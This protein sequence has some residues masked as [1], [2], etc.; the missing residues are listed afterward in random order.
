MK[1]MLVL[2]STIILLSF[3]SVDYSSHTSENLISQELIGAWESSFTTPEG[4]TMKAV[5]IVAE[6]YFSVAVFDPGQKTFYGTTGGKWTATGNTIT[7]TF[8]YD[9]ITK[10]NVG[11]SKIYN[12]T[13]SPTSFTI[14]GEPI[15]NRIDYGTPGALAGPWLITGRKRNGEISRRTPGARK[16]MKIL[17]GTRFQWIA[18]NVDTGEFFGTGGGTYTTADGKYVEN[19]DF[20]SR[21]GSRVGASLDFDYKLELASGEWHH[22]GFSGKGDPMFEIW[23]LRSVLDQ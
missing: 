14:E 15:R 19:I 20:F 6:S 23:T 4:Q 18:Y 2:M 8:E 11:Q 12:F 9:T 13:V 21:D 10:E 1:Y 16:T 7:A 17:S 22:S 5:T 3:S